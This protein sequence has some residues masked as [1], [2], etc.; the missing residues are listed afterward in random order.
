M[1]KKI[2]IMINQY[3]E[4][5]K[6]K[7]YKIKEVFIFG[8]FAKGYETDDSDIDLAI[9][10]E[11]IDSEFNEIVN[12]M[13]YRREFDLRIEPHPFSAAEFNV[14]NP[15]VEEIIHTGIKIA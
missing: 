7:D 14:S 10:L 8:S 9:V 11:D 4:Y 3:I 15:F 6:T 5:L 13:K 2:Y 1:D 12:L